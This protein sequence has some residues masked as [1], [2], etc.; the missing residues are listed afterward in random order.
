[1]SFNSDDSLCLQY[2][3]STTS[4]S[5][6][7]KTVRL[8][9]SVRCFADNLAKH[10]SMSS[11]QIRRAR[12]SPLSRSPFRRIP[13]S[14]VPY[15]DEATC[16]QWTQDLFVEKV[17]CSSTVETRLDLSF[18]RIACTTT[19]FSMIPSPVWVCRK[20]L[21]VGITPMRSLNSSGL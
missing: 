10:N 14:R 8:L 2:R 16:T 17:R 18:H 1:M 15:Q 21:S 19:S 5:P 3:L 7:R 13:I 20:F 12:S 9:N 4:C 11:T 6:S